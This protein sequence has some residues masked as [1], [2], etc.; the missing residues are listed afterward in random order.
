MGQ[1]VDSFPK[2]RPKDDIAEIS[3]SRNPLYMF[4][5]NQLIE[6]P[7]LLL[8]FRVWP[9]KEPDHYFKKFCYLVRRPVLF[10]HELRFG[11]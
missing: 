8:P 10:Q 4:Y 6:K 11:A 9:R 3:F 2:P 7:F 1:A 5:T